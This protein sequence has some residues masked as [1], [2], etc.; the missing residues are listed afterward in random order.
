LKY[1]KQSGC[2]NK[3]R[4][5]KGYCDVHLVKNATADSAREYSR[6]KRKNP[7]DKKYDTAHWRLNFRLK[8]LE[9]NFRCQK[10][11]GFDQCSNLATVVHHLI[12]PR[13][14]VDL[15][16]EPS[17]C[18]A[19]CAGCHPGGEAGTPD[20]KVGRDYVATVYKLPNFV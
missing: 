1:C 2:G 12:S 16:F 7:I 3:T 17:N 14:R 9:H 19:L 10:L 20:W 4:N 6:V 13:V 11:I 5:E 8:I 18:V 15:M